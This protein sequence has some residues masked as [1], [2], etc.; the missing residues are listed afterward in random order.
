LIS[1]QVQNVGVAVLSETTIFDGRDSFPD[2]INER[3]REITFRTL[4]YEETY[5]DFFKDIEQ[6]SKDA[7]DT[8]I[9]CDKSLLDD[10]EVES[11]K[12]YEDF[13]GCVLEEN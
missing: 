9:E 4:P 5:R 10:F 13:K 3:F 12:F 2:M 1:N 8:M 6:N 11:W 7:V